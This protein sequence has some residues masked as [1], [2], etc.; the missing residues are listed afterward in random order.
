[1]S[2]ELAILDWILIGTTIVLVL[3]GGFIGASSQLGALAGFITAPLAGYAGWGVACTATAALG[4]PEGTTATAIAAVLD[5]VIALVVFGLVRCMVKKFVRGCLGGCANAIAGALV[6]VFL[7]LALLALMVGVGMTPSGE[8]SRGFC[9]Q[10][11]A[12]VHTVAVWLDSHAG[13]RT[14]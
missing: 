7:S 9:A 14:Q 3:G 1:M 4:V 8:Y 6:G 12:I 10:R 11:S 13:G 2:V 5:L